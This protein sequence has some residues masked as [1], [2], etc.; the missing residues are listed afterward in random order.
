MDP[1]IDS[2]VAGFERG[3]VSRRE[4]IQK[5]TAIAAAGVGVAA[6]PPPSCR[7]RR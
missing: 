3:T 5:L 2:L 6:Q 1:V 7:R 4:L